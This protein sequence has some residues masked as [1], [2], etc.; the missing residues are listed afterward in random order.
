M[1]TVA[2]TARVLKLL[3]INS[4]VRDHV[5]IDLHYVVYTRRFTHQPREVIENFL[6]ENNYVQHI[7]IVGYIIN[8]MLV[9]MKFKYAFRDFT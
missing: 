3:R 7:I 4:R 6:L 1:T 2:F 8:K 9:E 5:V